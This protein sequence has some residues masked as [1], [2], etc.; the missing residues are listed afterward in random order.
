MIN[1]IIGKV[2]RIR[3]PSGNEQQSLKARRIKECRHIA[4][5]DLQKGEV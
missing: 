1:Y 2:G 3:K 4:M 5:S